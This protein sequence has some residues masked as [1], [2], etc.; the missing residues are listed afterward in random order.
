MFVKGRRP[1]AL[2][3]DQGLDLQLALLGAAR[4]AGVDGPA[5]PVAL[6]ALQSFAEQAPGASPVYVLAGLDAPTGGVSIGVSSGAEA[7]WV[8]ADSV[9]QVP[10]LL[11]AFVP[12]EVAGDLVS[13][14]IG[15]GP[16][17][18]V[19]SCRMPNRVT[20]VTVTHGDDGE[21]RVQQFLLPIRH[22]IPELP[23]PV[24]QRLLDDPLSMTRH[25]VRA[26]RQMAAGRSL[27]AVMSEPELERLLYGKWLDP[28]MAVFATYELIRRGEGADGGML[29]VVLQNL[30][31]HF[32]ELPDVPALE[33][34]AGIRRGPVR[35]APLVL[36]GLLSLGPRQRSRVL[37]SDRLDYRGPWTSWINAVE[38][39]E[40]A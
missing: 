9:E 24:R 1:T 36:D 21:L 20:F 13:I 29:A 15:S 10:D 28:I 7:R 39:E 27:A 35:R 33:R 11:Q 3:A 31:R 22:L 38:P 14:R 40:E 34:L 19:A 4:I 37:P 18:T 8:R 26:T 12:S 23:A 16:V 2:A 25:L 5:T 30:R 6:D 32:P 17:R